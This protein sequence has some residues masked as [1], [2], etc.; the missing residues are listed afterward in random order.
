M[1]FHIVAAAK[2]ERPQAEFDESLMQH[3]AQTGPVA[4]VWEARQSLVVPRTY[5]RYPAFTTTCDQFA[6]RGWPVT[7]RQSGGGLVPQGPGV[8]NLSLAYVQEGAPLSH[9]DGAYQVICAIIANTLAEFMI[10]TQAQ[11][12]AGSFCDGRYNLAWGTGALARKV[13]GTAQLWRRITPQ[14]QH[15]VRAQV[16]LVHALLLTTVDTKAVTHVANQF[17]A[18]LGSGRHYDSEKIVS[19]HDALARPGYGRDAFTADLSAALTRQL[20]IECPTRLHYNQPLV[21]P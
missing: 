20:A 19:L 18:A 16:V 15:A 13:A 3:A 10:F 21:I 11:E 17:E 1:T 14:E 8:L 2:G 9:S 12:V 7:V 6:R 4:C 5:R